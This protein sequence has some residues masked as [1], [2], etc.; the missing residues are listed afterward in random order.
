MNIYDI[1]EKAGVSIAT[2][3]RVLNNSAKVS[4]ATRRKVMEVV[5]QEGY[6]PN[7]FARGLMTNTMKTVGL[8]CQDAS[9]P[10][11]GMAINYLEAGLRSEDYEMLLCCTG[12]DKANK[13]K[14]LEQLLARK[15][16]AVILIGSSFVEKTEEENRYLYNA[17]GRVP[18][19]FVNGILNGG[20]IYGCMSDD[21]QAVKLAV[22]YALRSGCRAPLFLYRAETMSAGRKKAGFISAVEDAGIP[23]SERMCCLSGRSVRDAAQSLKKLRKSSGVFDL[24]MAADDE[25]AVGAVKY[26]IEE[27]LRIP[28]DISVIGYNNSSLALCCTPELTTVDNHLNCICA[29]VVKMLMKIFHHEE[30]PHTV[31]V[32]ASL[33]CR[34]TTKPEQGADE[35]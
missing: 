28:E 19:L 22:A 2:V 12:P 7:V 8:M 16:D 1:S 3:S 21:Y 9:D 26:A 4:E 25:L 29:E 10:Y 13:E 11:M 20:N 6:Q 5:E 23:F 31:T 33:V 24:V 15:V 27:G 34:E 17:A 35:N 30:T 14:C 32:P 18:I